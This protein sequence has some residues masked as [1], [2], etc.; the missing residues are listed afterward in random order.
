MSTRDLFDK[1]NNYIPQTDQRDAFSD[2]ESSRNAKSISEKQN[3]FEPQIDYRDP[4]SFARF[5]SAELYYQSALDRIIDFYPYDGSDAEY[6]EFYNNSLGIEKFIFNNLYPRTNGYINFADSYISLKGGPHTISS[7]S[8]KGLFKDP[9]SS[10]RETANI[11]DEELYTTEGLPSDYGDGTRESNLKCDFQKGVTVEFWLKNDRLASNTKRA[12]FHLTNSAGGDEFTLYLSGTTGSPFFTT[13]SASHNPVFGDEQIGTTPDTSSIGSWNHYAVS[14]KSA[15]SGITTR[16]YLNGNLDQTTTLGTAGVNTLTQPETLAYL[17]SGSHDESHLNF[18]GSMDEFRFWKVERTAQEIGRNWFGQ[19]RGGS[20]TDIS[21]TTLGVYYK[22]NEGITGVTAQDSVVLDYS[23]RISNGIFNGYTAASRNTGSAIVLAGAAAKEYLDPIIYANHPNVSSLKTS[24][25]NKGADHDLRNNSAFATFMP[26]WI[27]EEHEENGNTNFKK[28][29]HIIGAYFDKLYLQIESVSTLKSP[30]YTS[31]SYKPVSFADHL[32]SSMGLETP[33]IFINTSVLEKFLNKNETQAF[34]NDLNDVKNLIYLNLYNN[35][36]YLFKSKGTAKAVR[37]VLRAFN[38]DDKL[39]RFNTYANNFTYELK[40]NLKQTTIRKNSVNFNNKNNLEAVIYSSGSSDSAKL[41][42]ISGSNLDSHELRYGI[43]HETDIIFPK[44]IRSIDTFDRNFERVSLFG[45]HSASADTPEII[46]H[47]PSVYVYAQR[48]T[49]YSKNVKFVLSSSML[50]SEI[51]SSLYL[52]VYD[53]EEWNFSVRIKP[54]SIGLTGSVAS[55]SVADYTIEFSGY[56]QRLGQ[57][58][59][60]FKVADSVVDYT[61]AQGFLKSGKR[62]FAGA[63]RTNITGALQ[64]KSD[65]LVTS[66]RFWTQ[67][68]DDDSLKQ[69]A[70][71][72]ENYG[73]RDAN[74]H[75]SVLDSDN[76]KTL[77]INTLALNYEFGN[78]TAS[79]ALGNFLVTDIS[80][81]S[82]SGRN[83]EFGKLG[84]ISSYLYPGTGFGFEA[85]STNVVLRE[86]RN[87]HQFINPEMVIGDDLIQIRTDDDKL[88]DSVDTIPNYHHVLE[89]SMYNA[90][91]EEMLNFFAGV[92]DFHNLIGHPVHM[93]RMEYKGLNKLREIFFRKVTEVAEVE[94]FVE[95]YKWFDDAISQIVGQL[96]PASAEYTSDILNTVESHVL[97][98]PKFQHRIPMTAF[99]SSTEGVAFGAEELKYNWARNHAPISGLER[100]NSDWWRDRAER[101][102][103]ISSGDLGVDADRTQIRDSIVNRTNRGVG[104]SFAITGERYSSSPF[105]YRTI[106]K[107]FVVENKIS[108]EIKSGVNFSS[109]KNIH[110]TY[111]SLHPAGPV[112]T[113]DGVFIP[114]NVLLAFTSDL[115]ELEDTSDPPENPNAK[116]KRIVKVQHGR[117]WEEGIGYKNV[118]SSKAF[119]FN[120]FSSSVRSGYNAHVIAR[121]TASIEITNLH[122]DVYG[123]DMERPMQ[124][125]F[126][127][128]AVGGHQSRHIKLN[129]GGDNYLNRPEAWKILLGKCSTVTG[130]IGM[131]GADYPYPEANAV[132]ENPY[133]MTGAQKATYFRDEL[134]KRPVNIRNIHHTTGSTILG[135]YNHNYDIVQVAGGYS[136]PRAFID[137]QPLLPD[138][139]KGADVAKTILDIDRG[140]GGHFVFVDDYN[141]GYL[142]GSGD[143]KNETVIISRFSAPGSRESMTTAFKD[144]RAGELS[145]Y[146]SVP[147]RNMTTRRPF[148]GVTSSIVS[149]NTGMRSFDHTGRDFGFTNL[150]ARHATRFFRDST[151]I[152]DKEH[153]NVPRN[154][155]NTSSGPGNADN[156]FTEAPS[157]HKVHRNNLLRAEKLTSIVT[158][159]V[160]PSLQNNK[161][162]KLPALQNE[163]LFIGRIQSESSGMTDLDLGFRSSSFDSMKTSG[164]SYSSWVSADAWK[165]TPTEQ[166]LF[167]FGATPAASPGGINREVLKIK[168]GTVSSN[169]AKLE[170]FLYLW[171]GSTTWNEV[172]YE[173]DGFCLSASVGFQHV[174]VTAT[175]SDGNLGSTLNP[176][177][178]VDGVAQTLSKTTG[179]VYDYYANHDRELWTSVGNRLKSWNGAAGLFLGPF[180]SIMMIG[181]SSAQENSRIFSGSFDE[182]SLWSRPLSSLQVSEIYNGGVP[183]DLTSSAV[184]ASSSSDLIGWWRMGE[185]ADGAIADAIAPSNIGHYSSSVNSIINAANG[186]QLGSLTPLATKNNSNSAVITTQDVLA[187]CVP[188]A[189]QSEVTTYPCR[190]IYDNLNLHHQ[191]PR[192]DRQYSWIGAS[193]THTEACEPRY[194]GFMQVNSPIA[195]Y[196]EITGNYYPFFDYV[197]ASF[198]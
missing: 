189:V 87:A 80:S 122:N 31:S 75:I 76:N 130:A 55:V 25:V 156:A 158:N 114:K 72:F 134:A 165:S 139:V 172:G 81:G 9:E 38:I 28:L 105:K 42:Y 198:C 149:E 56:N 90:I 111:A 109:D 98:R 161:A 8:T 176:I 119:P 68:L 18:S 44:F 89:K 47:N 190:Q 153:S 62:I 83:G 179:V 33:D 135:N 99:T 19:V 63:H 133:P 69:H 140:R 29:S 41:G 13:L 115:V 137:E 22:F 182:T 84:E 26:S 107:A 191:I 106:S 32:P 168:R 152:P 54:S 170:L 173:T 58:R 78:V 74:K 6:N 145:V 24:L 181:G 143:Y 118:K 46:V 197:S 162:V 108:T 15:G 52:G 196:Y 112:N 94:R 91:S 188:T 102:G 163:S 123:T 35:L 127:N 61:K 34:E 30:F 177:A 66:T 51:S 113:D 141:T 183:C 67:Y 96:I 124:G 70:L 82:I 45:I 157:F 20:N 92:N 142:N 169:L 164:W 77:N 86:E 37:N 16:F 53:D 160:G 50:S 57:I 150:A 10:Q 101:I 73:I 11:Y 166:I 5:G 185:V 194:S 2:V 147:Y 17:A 131:V 129:D 154:F 40:N 126:T 43:T 121:A 85:N 151:I 184:Y 195:P 12:I 132:G 110:Y 187:G 3:S 171:D 36:T 120:I 60:S 146:N 1:S 159:Y 193:I 23:G 186:S 103:V 144:F 116:V 95:Y 79:D 64:H 7:T 48:D 125:P 174:V 65:I 97:E 14:F 71:D 100:D 175:G 178:Y 148:Q 180:E 49:T 155:V 93:Y 59:N 88:F 167:S 4:L 104:R 39:V 192:S 27:A 136:N 117:D 21:N 138:V 128:Y